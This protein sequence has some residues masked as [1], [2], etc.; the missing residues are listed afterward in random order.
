MNSKN[1]E[2]PHVDV[3][4]SLSSETIH[5]KTSNIICCCEDESK[6]LYF[7]FS[8][9]SYKHEESLQRV[10]RTVSIT[11]DVVGSGEVKW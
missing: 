8:V 11:R 3:E 7:Y 4:R 6:V 10:K 9:I 2:D 5:L 1:S